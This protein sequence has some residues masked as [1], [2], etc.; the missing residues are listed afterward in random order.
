M[1]DAMGRL[2][3]DFI[4]IGPGRT[5]TTWLHQMLAGHVDLPDGIKETGFFGPRFDKGFDWYAWHFRNATGE[6][7]I[8]EI[9]PYFNRMRARERIK[10]HLPDCRFICTLRNPVDHAYSVYKLMR[11]YVWTRTS[12][13]E[14]LEQRP[15][16][17]QSNRY[18]F[19]LKAWFKTFGREKVLVTNYDELK[20]SPQAYLDRICDFVGIENIL[21]PRTTSLEDNVNGF[22]RAPRSRHLAQNARHVLFW[23]RDHRAY[24]S[25]N[26]LER[27]GVWRYCFGRGEP[28]PRLT[29]ELERKLIARWLPEIDELEEL[30][31]WD[32]SH[33]KTPRRIEADSPRTAAA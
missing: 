22:S 21:L 5:G 4:G 26:L 30:L 2:L 23:L 25:A 10:E 31:D 13:E 14:T 15:H 16:L 32:L 20:A 8:A 19:N 27:I 11:H 3:P 9:S 24:R 17:D 28:F 29:P 6:R 1:R 7:K 12:L 18:C 33:W